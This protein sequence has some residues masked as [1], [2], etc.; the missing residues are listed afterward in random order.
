M[1]K[2][3]EI[4]WWQPNI[5]KVKIKLIDKV[6][7][8]NF[9]SEGKHSLNFEN[10]IKKFL[11]TKFCV[12]TSSGSASI[13]LALKSLGIGKGDEVI[14][15]NVT[16]IATANAVK[17]TGAKVVL[18]D[19]DLRNLS[20]D[21][22]DLLKRINKRTKVILPVHV[23]GRGGNIKKICSIAKK[24]KIYVVEDAAEAFGSKLSNKNLGT[25]GILG[26]FSFTP[27]KIIT[28]GQGGLVISNSKKLIEKII[29][30]K[31]QGRT[32]RLKGGDDIHDLE[33][34]N[35]KSNDLLAV[36]GLSQF[37]EINKRIKKIKFINKFYKDNLNTKN[38]SVIKNEKGEIPI[39][40][41]II[42]KKKD[43]LF[44]YLYENKIK[45]RKIWRPLS[46][47]KNYK[48]KKLLKN[49]E[50]VKKNYMWLPSGLNLQ[51]KDLNY[52]CKKINNFYSS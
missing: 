20:I 17:L 2:K 7:R 41:D 48:N 9:I 32:F 18:V 40:T 30:L 35:F 6:L 47:Q 10:K 22:K 11:K 15:P 51:K 16:Y 29:S 26:C 1:I 43:M 37:K 38:I 44:D 42:C 49:S 39:W 27:T 50:I 46:Y 8:S 25:F 45:C 52:I 31:D 23:S 36:L 24:K 28:T 14:V 13:Y 34:F 12:L 19:V 4:S 5:Q 33:G 21:I 3:K